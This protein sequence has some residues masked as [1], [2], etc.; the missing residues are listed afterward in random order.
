M[1]NRDPGLAAVSCVG[2][3]AGNRVAG[4]SFRRQ[5]ILVGR[6]G[7]SR[8]Q[9][10]DQTALATASPTR[11]PSR[12]AER[13]PHNAKGRH[14]ACRRRRVLTSPRCTPQRH[15]VT[16]ALRRG[17]APTSRGSCRRSC[18]LPLCGLRALS[19]T[20]RRRSSNTPPTPLLRQ[21]CFSGRSLSAGVE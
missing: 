17:R 1:G 10:S 4:C 20:T 9:C 7:C 19:S 2:R 13:L 15:R 14:D 8:T 3:R 11:L 18:G 21:S 12:G 6:R 5:S 16:R